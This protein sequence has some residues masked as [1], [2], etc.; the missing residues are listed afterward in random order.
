MLVIYHKNV[1]T[2]VRRP[3]IREMVCYIFFVRKMGI[4][5][6]NV[7][8]YMAWK[9]AIE[10]SVD[11]HCTS[12]CAVSIGRV[13][14]LTPLLCVL[15]SFIYVYIHNKSYAF[16]YYTYRSVDTFFFSSP[17]WFDLI[18][19]SNFGVHTHTHRQQKAQLFVHRLIIGI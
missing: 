9:R 3:M 12:T 13:V 17:R 1:G 15:L 8:N 11:V 10:L 6:T 4:R 7:P 16:T 14:R 18:F 5:T 2:S 19:S